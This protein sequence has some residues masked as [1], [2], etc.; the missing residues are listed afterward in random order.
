VLP[1]CREFFGEL[2]LGDG[3]VIGRLSAFKRLDLNEMKASLPPPA[4]EVRKQLALDAALRAGMK[5]IT[6]YS[7]EPETAAS[8]I[9]ISPTEKKKSPA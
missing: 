5:P 2:R 7:A 1:W 8:P 6:P 4:A 9:K 3:C